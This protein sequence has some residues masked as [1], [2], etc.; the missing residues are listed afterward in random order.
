MP[1]LNLKN[2]PNINNKIQNTIIKNDLTNSLLKLWLNKLSSNW[3][4]PKIFHIFFCFHLF[5]AHI[6]KKETNKMNINIYSLPIKNGI[7]DEKST[8]GK[9]PK[10]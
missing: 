10:I 7:R 1:V 2:F 5:L 6:F 4:N 9:I 3:V 8:T